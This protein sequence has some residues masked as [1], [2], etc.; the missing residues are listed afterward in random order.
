LRF[1]LPQLQTL[2]F[3]T[4][5]FTGQGTIY[6]I[7]ERGHFWHSAP[8]RWMLLSS[9]VDVIAVSSLAGWGILMGPLPMNVIVVVLLACLAYLG[10]LDFLKVWI[11]RRFGYASR[12]CRGA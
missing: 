11:L 10:A 9:T 5:V 8:S 3:V 6:M 2:V 12:S 4:L 1:P 7:R